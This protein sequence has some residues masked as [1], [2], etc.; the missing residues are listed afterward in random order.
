MLVLQFVN[1]FERLL[2]LRNGGFKI[3]KF[4]RNELEND[5]ALGN[6]ILSRLDNAHS[7]LPDFLNEMVLVCQHIS[8]LENEY[9]F[10]RRVHEPKVGPLLNSFMVRTCEIEIL[11]NLV[12]S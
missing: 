10:V 1:F 6:G 2:E 11:R 7:T 9:R 4:A 3:L 8:R 5:L 12:V